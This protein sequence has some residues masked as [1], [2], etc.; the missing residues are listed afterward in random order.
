DALKRADALAGLEPAGIHVHIGSQVLEVEPYLAAL[1]VVLDLVAE[2]RRGLELALST[3]DLGGG[4]GVTYT[5]ERPPE[6]AVLGALVH[7][8]LAAAAR[9]RGI[10]PPDLVVE[11]GRAIVANPVLTLYRVGTIKEVPGV[12]TYVSVDGGMSDNIRPALYGSRYAFALANRPGADERTPVT[13][14][15]RHSESGDIL[16]TDVPVPAD[17]ER[18]D[19][20]A[21]AATG[22]YAYAMASTYNRAGRPAAVA[23]G[24]G[25]ARLIL[26]REEDGDLDRLE[27]SGGPLP[28]AAPPAGVVVRPARPRDARSFLA[29]WTGVVAERRFVRTEQVRQTLRAERR[30]F[31]HSWTE[32]GTH[33]VAVEGRRV[34]GQLT[35]ARDANA[36]NHHVATLGIAIAPDRRG[37]GIGAALMS[38]CVRW[39]QQVGVEKL[40]LSVYPENRAALALYAKFGFVEEGRLSG[41]SKK[42][43]GYEDEIVMG[44]WLPGSRS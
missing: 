12:R 20:L 22:A 35:A 40:A 25:E 27:M 7:Q 16:G 11:P 29:L 19:L 15:G 42:S 38:T 18:G 23:L 28:E 3:L 33:L 10:A 5:D 41:H 30:R 43:Y 34:V 31:K 44:R 21:V 37:R 2:A 32:Q 1:E 17:I 26:R 4:F 24:D 13:V 9:E 39:A 8:R 14:A 36:V 6:P